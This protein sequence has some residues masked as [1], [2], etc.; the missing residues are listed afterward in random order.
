MLVYMTRKWKGRKR[1]KT[2]KGGA[3]GHSTFGK[4]VMIAETEH[5][6]SREA[7]PG[8]KRGML[9]K[10][11]D[12]V[13]PPRSKKAI[14][15][16]LAGLDDDTTPETERKKKI[17]E[18]ELAKRIKLDEQAAA[19]QAGVKRSEDS[20][21]ESSKKAEIDKLLES[22]TEKK[23][24]IDAKL[25]KMKKMEIDNDKKKLMDEL[26]PLIDD[27]N[28]TILELFKKGVHKM[29]NGD[30]IFLLERAGETIGQP[31]KKGDTG[32]YNGQQDALKTKNS[33][34]IQNGEYTPKDVGYHE[35]YPKKISFLEDLVNLIRPGDQSR[36]YLKN[37]LEE[38][39][40][41]VKNEKNMKYLLR[42]ISNQALNKQLECWGKLEKSENSER[43][44]ATMGML[45]TKKSAAFLDLLNK[46]KTRR[47]EEKKKV[48]PMKREA[49]H[50]FL[51]GKN[52][53]IIGSTSKE[54]EVFLRRSVRLFRHIDPIQNN[55]DLKFFT[56]II[57]CIIYEFYRNEK[58]PLDHEPFMTKFNIDD[59]NM[60]NLVKFNSDGSRQ[61]TINDIFKKLRTRLSCSSRIE[62]ERRKL[63]CKRS[64]VSELLFPVK[65][66]ARTLLTAEEKA[67]IDNAVEVGIR[68]E[69][70][71][72]M[73]SL[74][75]LLDMVTGKE[76]KLKGD[77]NTAIGMGKAIR[78]LLYGW[79]QS[80]PG[81]AMAVRTTRTAVTKPLYN[82]T[83]KPRMVKD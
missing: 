60:K 15:A 45:P 3:L 20:L 47:E 26:T 57:L 38:Y 58:D 51:K 75:S 78:N 16:D 39:V 17:L 69:D 14:N 30:N 52:D 65:T 8:N 6:D 63:I 24:V 73:G 9:E 27:I 10:F 70:H 34:A 19:K 25:D 23:A 21:K 64:E 43:S 28:E 68:V 37:L 61:V 83:M 77:G 48:L 72:I 56:R 5:N 76:N 79:S 82:S 2:R 74:T 36:V 81:V 46:E 32:D 80:V 59:V 42:D 66:K 18:T 62:Q 67:Q 55:T 29:E 49:L 4:R 31:H 53:G 33:D 1:R 41:K 35:H 54:S 7:D 44:I 71:Q 11:S 13:K 12:F 50:A 22:Y 40:P